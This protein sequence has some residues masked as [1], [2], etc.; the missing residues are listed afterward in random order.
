MGKN[1]DS[2]ASSAATT[3]TIVEG[4]EFSSNLKEVNLKEEIGE[5]WTLMARS[6]SNRE[7]GGLRR[8]KTDLRDRHS[9]LP[10]PRENRMPLPE[11]D[12]DD[13][14]ESAQ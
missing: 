4:E 10:P 8:A 7:E 3:A 14:D 5:D 12:G 1:R 9:R 11:E 2:I 6:S 13:S